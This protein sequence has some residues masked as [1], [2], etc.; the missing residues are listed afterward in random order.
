[1]SDELAPSR[2]FMT[3]R[4]MHLRQVCQNH[5]ANFV[6]D[7]TQTTALRAE[8]RPDLFLPVTFAS[9]TKRFDSPVEGV[10]AVKETMTDLAMQVH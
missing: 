7:C 9:N 6:R 2:D 10:D 1:M 4:G 3:D 5:N 8:A